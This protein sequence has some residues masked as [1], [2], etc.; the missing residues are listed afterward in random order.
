MLNLARFTLRLLLIPALLVLFV[1]R[2]LHA[3][4]WKR[5]ETHNFILYSEGS[6]SQLEDFA[7][8]LERL[9][10]LLRKLW[11]K[12]PIE[13]PAKLTVY[14]LEDAQNVSALAGRRRSDGLL[15]GFYLARPEG[16]FFVGNRRRS[17]FAERLTG[18]QVLYHEYA[19]HFFFQNF[20]IP[21]PAWFAEGFA[22]FVSTAEFLPDDQ[23]TIG[24]FAARHTVTLASSRDYPFEY[25]LRGPKPQ[26]D[27]PQFY[28]WS[29]ALTHF[30]YS[31]PQGSGRKLN[32][33]LADLND[34]TD[35]MAAAAVAF[36]DRNALEAAVKSYVKEP[37]T[38]QK[39]VEPLVYRDTVRIDE[40]DDTRSQLVELRLQRLMSY[41][42]GDAREDLE[43]IVES[44]SAN[45]D[46][47][48]ELAILHYIRQ[49]GK[50]PEKRK[51]DKA[52]EAADR[53]LSLDP[54]NVEA[55]VLRG[56][57]RVE[58]FKI[59]GETD[60]DL[61]AAGIA[62][63]EAAVEAAP[64][65]PWALMNL[66]QA[67]AT[68]RASYARASEL[69]ERAFTLAPEVVEFRYQHA[70]ALTTRGEYDRA[71]RLLEIIANN[72]HGRGEDADRIIESIRE[73]RERFGDPEGAS[74]AD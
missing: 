41:E 72:P 1:P 59:A 20:S 33:Y 22:D 60:T 53:A 11:R 31:E 65:T 30:L 48:A 21:A 38:F 70:F 2:P 66:A 26:R 56:R 71:I 74:D 49:Q 67:L 37:F 28:A 42:L 45:A 5:A 14:L 29:W 34:G 57:M 25:L 35:P 7:R 3:G 23:W 51:L 61:L 50:D 54:T 24:K 12:D 47:W 8:D 44:G 43:N 40:L 27:V 16:S 68:E 10:A 39:S 55:L 58:S 13:N 73:I 17:K 69:T 32:D 9:D 36:G 18:R 64:R 52:R 63:L 62:D 15:A 6:T 4:D 46:A 19:H